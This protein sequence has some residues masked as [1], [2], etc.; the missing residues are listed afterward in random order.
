MSIFFL[1]RMTQHSFK[2]TDVTTCETVYLEAHAKLL[3]Y[4]NWNSPLI[5]N[6]CVLQFSCADVPYIIFPTLLAHYSLNINTNPMALHSCSHRKLWPKHIKA[7]GRI[8]NVSDSVRLEHL[9][10]HDTL[11][12]TLVQPSKPSLRLQYTVRDLLVLLRVGDCLRN[13]MR[14]T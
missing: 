12:P 11:H 8:H 14:M 3:S 1:E 2:L 13:N 6:H 4:Y 9:K 10:I 7:L 5:T